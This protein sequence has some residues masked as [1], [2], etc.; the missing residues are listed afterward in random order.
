MNL[1]V[2]RSGQTF[3]PYTIEQANSFLNSNQLLPSDYA[4][5][6]GTTEWKLLPD[7]LSG[8]SRT[9]NVADQRMILVLKMKSIQF[10]NRA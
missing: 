2:S 10:A 3:G 1:Y 6:E 7:I 9:G 4:L 8:V 5:I